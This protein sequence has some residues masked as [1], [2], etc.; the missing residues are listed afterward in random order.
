M[1]KAFSANGKTGSSR[2]N[3][4]GRLFMLEL[5]GGRIHSMTP[6]GGDRKVIVTHCR[7]PDGI[8]VDVA[9][10]HIYWTNMGVLISTMAPSSGP[11]LT[12]TIVK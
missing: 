9:T 6:E 3:T 1:A 8:A 4:M 11:T 7:H 2:R 10:G 12:E 5:S